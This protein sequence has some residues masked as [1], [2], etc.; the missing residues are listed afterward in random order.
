MCPQARFRLLFMYE[1]NAPLCWSPL[2][3][4]L[5]RAFS[6]G[7]QLALGYPLVRGLHR[8]LDD[9]SLGVAGLVSLVA[10]DLMTSWADTTAFTYGGW[11]CFYVLFWF[12]FFLWLWYGGGDDGVVAMVV[13]I[14]VLITEMI[15]SSVAF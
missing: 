7:C 1:V 5:Y 10:A 12:C 2:P 6:Q 13:V 8:F 4:G 11:Y 15:V 3:M 9:E 14:M